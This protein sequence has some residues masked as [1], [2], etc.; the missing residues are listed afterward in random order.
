MLETTGAIGKTKGDRI[1]ARYF[2]FYLTVFFFLAGC[3][4]GKTTGGV[5]ETAPFSQA[6]VESIVARLPSGTV[7]I[8]SVSKTQSV[9]ASWLMGCKINWVY[10]YRTKTY[11]DLRGCSWKWF[12]RISRN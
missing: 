5:E 4:Q 7:G 1:M 12:W 10:M 6:E 2:F 11:L 8:Y 3:S 9:T